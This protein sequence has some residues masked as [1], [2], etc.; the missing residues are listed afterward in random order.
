M[1]SIVHRASAEDNIGQHN[2]HKHTHT[3]THW[4]DIHSR[5][6]FKFLTLLGIEPGPAGWKADH[7]PN[8]ILIIL[9]LII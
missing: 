5:L 6:E 7:E 9:G 1:R 2:T 4:T 8:K 3:H